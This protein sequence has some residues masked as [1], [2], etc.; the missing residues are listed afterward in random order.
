MIDSTNCQFIQDS[1]SLQMTYRSANTGVR[2]NDPVNG[3]GLP[4]LTDRVD[5]NCRV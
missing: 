2:V 4:S 5:S 3:L 1:G